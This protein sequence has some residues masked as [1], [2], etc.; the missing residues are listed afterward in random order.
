MAGFLNPRDTSPTDSFQFSSRDQNG[1]AI[2][3][4]NANEYFL[5]T[6]TQMSLITAVSV[7]MLSLVNGEKT[8]YSIILVPNTPLYSGD[9]F[10]I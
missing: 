6:M 4:S 5:I 1:Y 2:D 8:S 10:I 3:A 9:I 7:S